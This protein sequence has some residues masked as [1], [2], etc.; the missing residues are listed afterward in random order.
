MSTATTPAPTLAVAARRALPDRPVL[1]GVA[2]AFATALLGT[3]LTEIGPWYQSLARPSWQPP[4]W[5]FGPAWTTIFGLS[6]VAFV[7]AWRRA[8]ERGRIALLAVYAA[9][10]AFNA[11]WSLL[12][13]TMKRPDWALWETIPLAASVTAMML[14]AGRHSRASAWL[15]AP[16]LA[17]VLFATFLN[18]T[19]LRLNPGAIGG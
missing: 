11:A 7:L 6:T 13:F 2:W 17:W 15:L 12:F 1:F 8:P 4:D 5:A 14:V 9:N 19:L 18:W 3:A 16:Y 10:G